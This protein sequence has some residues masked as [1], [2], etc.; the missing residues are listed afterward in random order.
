MAGKYCHP[1]TAWG[2]LKSYQQSGVWQKNLE[3]LL[4]AGYKLGKIN[5]DLVGV[6]STTIKSKRKVNGDQGRLGSKWLEFGG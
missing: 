6:D 5:L 3:R 1:A 2:R 4:D